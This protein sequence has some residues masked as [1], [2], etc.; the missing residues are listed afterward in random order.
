L[1]Q[2]VIEMK[3]CFEEAKTVADL[4]IFKDENDHIIA[5]SKEVEKLIKANFK[6]NRKKRAKSP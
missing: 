4:S 1:A 3:E 6:G 2:A 5:V